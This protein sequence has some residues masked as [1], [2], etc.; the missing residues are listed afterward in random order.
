MHFASFRRTSVLRC[1]CATTPIC[2]CSRSHACPGPHRQRL[3]CD[4]IE[5]GGRCAWRWKRR[6]GMPE[7]W[8]TLLA[9]V[10]AFDPPDDLRERVERRRTHE[11]LTAPRRRR[12]YRLLIGSIAATAGVATV[13]V[14]LAL[15]AHSHSTPAPAS[16]ASKAEA[17][18]IARHD[19][20]KVQPTTHGI[21]LTCNRTAL[22]FMESQPQ[23]PDPAGAIVPQYGLSINDRRLKPTVRGRG[24]GILLLL[25]L[26]SAADARRCAAA[27][28][29]GAQHY[30]G[31]TPGTTVPYRMF[32]SVTVDLNPH[33]A[34][35]PGYTRGTTGGFDTYI[36]RGRM[37][38]V[39]TTDNEAQ[40][41]IAEADLRQL[42]SQIAH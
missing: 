16:V 25:A 26:P 1:S 42:L 9:D 35:V 2:R 17:M 33:S 29:Y 28:I 32:S 11:A 21:L 5:P 34:N 3:E 15:A 37:L 40:A 7:T 38:A 19:G 41:T 22:D 31:Q 24:G 36:A 27:G 6:G 30:E 23:A 4:C 10:G 13:I 8:P 12:P 14:L 39:G 20:F 18:S